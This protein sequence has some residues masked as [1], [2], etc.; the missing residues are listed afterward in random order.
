MKSKKK[1]ALGT[2]FPLCLMG[3]LRKDRALEQTVSAQFLQYQSPDAGF[4]QGEL[5]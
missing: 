3:K 2:F 1:I 4:C 5:G